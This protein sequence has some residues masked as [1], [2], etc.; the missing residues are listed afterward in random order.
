MAPNGL[1]LKKLKGTP[2]YELGLGLVEALRDAT[3]DTPG[4]PTM[5]TYGWLHQL[6]HSLPVRYTGINIMLF[7]SADV[8]YLTPLFC[9][10]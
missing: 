3:C 1:K 8:P 2:D 10:T 5:A 6:D 9:H 7:T 4:Y